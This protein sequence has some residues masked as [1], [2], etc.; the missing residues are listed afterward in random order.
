MFPSSKFTENSVSKKTTSNSAREEQKQNIENIDNQAQNQGGGQSQSG[1][2]T[3]NGGGQSQGG[4]TN[5]GGG[6][7]S[8]GGQSQNNGGGNSSGGGQPQDNI[9]EG[10]SYS[11]AEKQQ[12]ENAGFTVTQ[13]KPIGERDEIDDSI[14]VQ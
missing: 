12:L 7:Q 6:Q 4:N 5:N 1:G 11:E 14:I 9:S 13:G 2:N 10:G 3:N 8:S